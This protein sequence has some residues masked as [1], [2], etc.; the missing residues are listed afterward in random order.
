M[1]NADNT[2]IIQVKYRHGSSNVRILFLKKGA[3]VGYRESLKHSP[4]NR[5][6]R[7]I[8]NELI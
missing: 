2:S 5:K 4:D 3:N 8:W 7:G 1:S 6:N